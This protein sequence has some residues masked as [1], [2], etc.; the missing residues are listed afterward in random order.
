MAPKI[1]C[2]TFCFLSLLVAYAAADPDPNDWWWYYMGLNYTKQLNPRWRASRPDSYPKYLE[3]LFVFHFYNNSRCVDDPYPDEGVFFATRLGECVP[4][5]KKGDGAGS[6]M[7]DDCDPYTGRIGSVNAYLDD[8]CGSLWGQYNMPSDPYACRDVAVNGGKYI[9]FTFKHEW[10]RGYAPQL[11]DCGRHARPVSTSAFPTFPPTTTTLAG[12]T[13]PPPPPVVAPVALVNP[14]PQAQTTAVPNVAPLAAPVANANPTPQAQTTAVPNPLA[15]HAAPAPQA[16]GMLVGVPVAMATSVPH[17]NPPT[18]LVPHLVDS[19][20]AVLGAAP[21]P[22]TTL[23][24]YLVAGSTSA[25][26]APLPSASASLSGSPPTTSSPAQAAA[27][28]TTMVPHLVAANGAVLGVAPTHV[29]TLVPY[30]VAP[31]GKVLGAA[32]TSTTTTTTTSEMPWG[33]PWW[34]WFLI[35]CGTLLLC[36]MCFVPVCCAPAAV[37]SSSKTTTETSYVVVDEPDVIPTATTG[38]SGP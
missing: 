36:L 34:A 16:P 19:N 9:S 27:H 18:T 24:P 33:L 32:S 23:V 12:L 13:P 30:L 31:G 6:Y 21:T 26:M 10:I 20:G 5:W 22:L 38:L 1:A 7:V 28:P 17:L 35:C 11:T 25:T 3:P 4:G 29:T 2:S 37:R 8:N 15:A 14:T